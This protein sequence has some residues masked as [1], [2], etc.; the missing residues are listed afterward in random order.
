MTDPGIIAPRVDG[1]LFVLRPG[2][3]NRAAAQR[4]KEILAG[5]GGRLLGVVV[6]GIG[7][8]D[9]GAQYSYSQYGDGQDYGY[10]EYY[11]S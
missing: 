9:K 8:R 3:N 6:N 1:V 4:A 10:T 5:L 7:A 11:Q 2:N